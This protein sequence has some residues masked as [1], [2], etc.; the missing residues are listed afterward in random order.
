MKTKEKLAKALTEAN[1]PQEMIAAA[2][3]GRYDDFESHSATPIVDLVHDCH[4]A[5]L[6][7]IADRAMNGDFD[8]TKEESE[9]WFEREGKGLL[10]G[11]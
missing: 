5:G 10:N 2:I 11:S 4:H 8:A 7:D 3:S 9:A 1:A 6:T